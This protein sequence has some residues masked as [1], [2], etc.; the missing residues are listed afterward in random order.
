MGS[1]D[2]KKISKPLSIIIVVFAV[3]GVISVGY[4][5]FKGIQ[6]LLGNSE[7]NQNV[8]TLL[9][10]AKENKYEGEENSNVYAEEKPAEVASE[11]SSG[12]IFV[13]PT[14]KAPENQNET[15]A[16]EQKL[17]VNNDGRVQITF[18]GD[19]ILDNFRGETGI[20]ELVAKELDAKVYNIAIGGTPASVPRNGSPYDDTFDGECGLAVTKILAGKITIDHI[21]ACEAKTIISEHAEDIKKS[22]IF[23]IEYGINDFL[24]G[25]MRVNMDDLNDP[26]TYEGGLRMMI[27]DLQA[28]NPNAAIVLCQ[29]TYI[30]LYRDNGEYVGNTYTLD[31]GPGTAA[32]YN[33]TMESVANALGLYIFKHA[34]TGIDV[35]NFN[36]TVLDGIHLNEN[37]R[38]I[39]AENFSK[40]LKTQVI[41][42]LHKGD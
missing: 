30:E 39:Y 31:N 42:N 29:T 14:Q 7:E 17:D 24:A 23:V 16:P 4:L 21:Y 9:E 33:G 3:I 18:L 12:N 27:Y 20:C 28:I 1:N 19:S 34:D 37:G 26:F 13:D 36:D 5:G 38:A 41:P 22:D 35:Y 15:P 6:S 32:D 11:E 25:R 40:F 8:A 10:N 2:K